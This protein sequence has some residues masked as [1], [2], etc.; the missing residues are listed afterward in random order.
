MNIYYE[1]FLQFENLTKGDKCFYCDLCPTKKPIKGAT[2]EGAKTATI[3]H[4]AIQHHELRIHMEKDSSLSKDFIL[5][6]YYDIDLK[7]AQNAGAAAKQPLINNG[8][9]N[10]PKP[11]QKKTDQKVTVSDKKR[12]PGPK[13]KT[14]PPSSDENSDIPDFSDS[15]NKPSNKDSE[16]EEEPRINKNYIRK[17]PK[18]NLTMEDLEAGSEDDWDKSPDSSKKK[19]SNK[20][21]SHSSTAKKRV[22]PRRQAARAAKQ[23]NAEF[24]EEDESS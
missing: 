6:V 10:T 18:I 2:E 15:E 7:K 20:K 3:C 12:K 9:S 4:L 19:R 24:S 23:K 21:T 11:V 13:S 22:M 5:D 17:R 8:S 1:F 14:R 16:E